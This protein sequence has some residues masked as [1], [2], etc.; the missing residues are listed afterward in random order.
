MSGGPEPISAEGL[1]AVR[2]ELA[3]L[4]VER[5]EVAATLRGDGPAGD[6]AD[7]ADELQRASDVTRL[8]RRIAELEGRL[9]EAEVAGAPSTEVIGVGSTVTVRFS[10]GEEE[11]V[12]ISELAEEREMTLVTYDSPLGKALLGRR[13][14]ETVNY[15]TPGGAASAVVLAV[16][17]GR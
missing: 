17:N 2:E 16:G 9:R 7:A 13:A 5:G 6:S 10:D 8:D 12:E 3:Q 15:E 11:T 1:R 4:R 14:G